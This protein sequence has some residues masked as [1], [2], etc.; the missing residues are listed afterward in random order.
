MGL[1]NLREIK[2]SYQLIVYINEWIKTTFSSCCL[3]EKL[4][5]NLK[6]KYV[7]GENR[8]NGE[9]GRRGLWSWKSE[10]RLYDSQ[11]VCF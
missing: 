4:L 6:L 8:R 3:K 1:E 9:R 7:S 5:G 11:A 2:V 10:P